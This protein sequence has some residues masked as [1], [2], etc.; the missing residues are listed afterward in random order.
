MSYR[1]DNTK[2]RNERKFIFFESTQSVEKLLSF[3]GAKEFYSPRM[4]NSIYYDT[5]FHKNFHEAI[6]GIMRRNK[7]RVRWYGK[8]FN[9]EIHPQIENKSRINQHNYKITKK[10]KSFRSKSSFDLISFK[11]YIRGEKNSKGEINFYLNNLYPSLFVSYKRKYF[12]FGDI[13][14]TLDADLKFINLAKTNFFSKKNFLCINKKKIIELKYSDKFHFQA[15]K[16]TKMFNNRLDKF[17]KYQI[18]FSETF[19]R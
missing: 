7:V 19:Y 15:K 6:D 14:I 18:G 16:V 17:S 13:R 3:I 12:V 1:I 5:Y 4:V 11:K 8:V 2:L 9:T 10:L